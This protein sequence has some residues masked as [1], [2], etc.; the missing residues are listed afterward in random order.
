[1]IQ[2]DW[3]GRSQIIS[4][5][6]RN[7]QGLFFA[8]SGTVL[9]STE[10]AMR[11][12]DELNIV[13]KSANYGFPCEAYGTFYGYEF[14][15]PQK[16]TKLVDKNPSCAG[17]KFDAPNFYWPEKTGISQG[18]E[19]KGNE[20]HAFNGNLLIGSLSGT[21]LYRIQLGEAHNVMF[22][23]RINLQE[24]VRDLNVSEDGKILVLTDGG[25]ILVL[26]STK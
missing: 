20:F 17:R 10:H 22:I 14:G 23:E 13:R 7:P 26:S 11:G 3:S 25:S 1:V 6:H 16:E 8:K 19:Y 21:S 5:G 9:L 12:G 4:S 15:S 2:V 18:I 24:R